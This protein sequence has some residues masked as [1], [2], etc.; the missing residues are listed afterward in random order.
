MVD[1]RFVRNVEQL[2]DSVLRFWRAREL[3]RAAIGSHL[4]YFVHCRVGAVHQFGLS[5]YCAFRDVSVSRYVGSLR[6]SSDGHITQ[7]HIQKVAGGEWVAFPNVAANVRGA[8][9]RWFTGFAPGDYDLGRVSILSI[10]PK[11]SSGAGERRLPSSI[12]P[13]ALAERLKAQERSGAAGERIAM[14]FEIRRLAEAGITNPRKYV[15]HVSLHNA[16]AGYDIYTFAR[17]MERF[18]EV[19]TSGS[20]RGGSFISAHQLNTLRDLKANAWLYQVD[21]STRTVKAIQDPARK[22]NKSNLQPV[23]FFYRPVT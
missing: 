19:K 8:F 21:L 13:E 11:R 17:G 16:A 20:G 2:E 15:D 3:W 5:K 22:L 14:A 1:S 18:I 10:G 23:L 9:R 7:K 12:A 4:K 6:R